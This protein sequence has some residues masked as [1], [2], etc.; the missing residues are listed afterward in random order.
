MELLEDTPDSP[1]TIDQSVENSLSETSESS[2][3]PQVFN[4]T[5][6]NCGCSDIE[7]NDNTFQCHGCGQFEVMQAQ[8]EYK[9]GS[10]AGN[11]RYTGANGNDLQKTVYSSAYVNSGELQKSTLITE[12]TKNLTTYHQKS[13]EKYPL[14]IVPECIDMYIQINEGS[15]HRSDFKRRLIAGCYWLTCLQKGY[16]VSSKGLAVAFNL[17]SKGISNGLSEVVRKLTD[18]GDKSITTDSLI[19]SINSVF[20]R[21]GLECFDSTTKKYEEAKKKIYDLIVTT[22]RLFV[23]IDSVQCSKIAGATY[24]IM[25]KYYLEANITLDKISDVVDIRIAT[26]EKYINAI[27]Q[28]KMQLTY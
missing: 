23:G 13:G 16:S 27:N 8:L 20:I 21:L 6:T 24:L 7:Y 17:K 5:C 14:D 19:P 18:T 26:I 28:R 22:N 9:T 10:T 15:V 12:I 3:F 4:Y 25:S 1:Y 11:I 2:E